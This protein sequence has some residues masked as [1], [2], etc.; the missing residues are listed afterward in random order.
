VSERSDFDLVHLVKGRID[1]TRGT[2]L[3]NPGKRL[4]DPYDP[5][6]LGLYIIQFHGPIKPEWLKQLESHDLLA[7]QYL[8]YNAYLVSGKPEQI[9]TFSSLPFVQFTDIF[10][11]SL[12]SDFVDAV[13]GGKGS[14]VVE[15][16]DPKRNQ[17]VVDHVRGLATS[18]PRIH[19]QGEVTSV[20]AAFEGA[21]VSG[22]V[23]LPLVVGVHDEPRG[24]LSDERMATSLTHSVTLA[25]APMNP[26]AYKAWLKNLCPFCDTLAADLFKV[27]IADFLGLDGGDGG[28]HHSDLPASRVEYGKSFPT[29]TPSSPP[30]KDTQGHASLVAGVIAGDPSPSQ[31]RDPGGFFYG[32]GIAPSTKVVVTAF[33]YDER[34]DPGIVTP[35]R[36]LAADAV[37]RGAYIQNHSYNQYTTMA[38]NQQTGLCNNQF[39]G[40]YSLMSREFDFA[41]RN[42]DPT[43]IPNAPITLTTS[44]G[45]IDQQ[46]RFPSAECPHLNPLLTLP[47]GTSKNAISVGGAESVRGPSEQW[48]CRASRADSYRNVMANSK[49][50]TCNPGWFKPD[51]MA[52]ASNVTSM[53]ST[54]ISVTQS[55]PIGFCTIFPL[56]DGLPASTTYIGSTGTSFAAPSAAAAAVL[57]SRVYAER[58]RGSGAPDPQVASPALI[59]A[60]L[61]AAARSMR[62]G[63]DRTTGTVIGPVP[64]SQQGFG[65]LSLEEV[66]N[67]YPSRSFVNQTITLPG[68][69]SWPYTWRVHDPT[70]P[71]KVALVW[72]DEPSLANYPNCTS[73]PTATPLMNDLDLSVTF[74]SPCAS[75]FVGNKLGVVNES[76]GETSV[77]YGCGDALPFDRTNNVELVRFFGAADAPFTVTVTKATGANSQDFALVVYNAYDPLAAVATPRNLVA[78]ATS[79]S[80]V[81]LQWSSPMNPLLYEVWERSNG[82]PYALLG[83]STTASF[84]HSG[85][86][87]G[88]VHL[89]KV[90][91]KASSGTYSG[92]SDVDAAVTFT[93]AD[94]PLIVGTTAVRALHIA[95]LREAVD[96]MRV[97]VGLPP[98]HFI[99]RRADYGGWDGKGGSYNRATAGSQ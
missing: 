8:P 88:A 56:S 55:Q 19:T 54:G 9:S 2:A 86:S 33:A 58:V 52:P 49:H 27:G 72:T 78:G 84:V 32:S 11:P 62:G 1:V 53:R 44:A 46:V 47:P 21:V 93:F 80:T 91:A 70:L 50:G 28:T 16:A 65:R 35:P 36:Q 57:A 83:T 13:P 74:G 61:I 48:N 17:S 59:K 15:I 73:G 98:R 3:S 37:L 6:E 23:E 51:L 41:V 30:M 29:T 94:D 85:A 18:T 89:Y 7:V 60:I 24:A 66:V 12:K 71:V 10:H 4:R 43:V 75:K 42:S 45:N 64:N 69:S 87:T 77:A 67:P 38:T 34:E 14:Y 95:Q 82:A 92:F 68:G 90:R 22:L 96:L 76:N 97:A 25:G 40:W 79:G 5:S 63:M 99:H 31:L 26:G 39:D 20:T 81:T